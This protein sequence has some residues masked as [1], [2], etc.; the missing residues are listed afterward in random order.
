MCVERG[1]KPALPRTGKEHAVA[2]TD[3]DQIREWWTT[4]PRWNIGIACTA[5]RL[6]VIDIDGP[7][8]VEWI[9]DHHLP[10]PDTWTATTSEGRYHY[11]YRWPEGTRIKTRRIA[12]E[13]EIRAAGAYLVAP[14]SIHPDGGIY[15]WADSTRCDWGDLPEVPAAHLDNVV[16]FERGN[17]VALKR[18]AGLADHLATKTPKGERH[19]ALYT[20]SRTLGGSSPRVTSPPHRSRRS[21]SRPPNKMAFS[22]RMAH[23]T[24][25]RPLATASQKVSPMAPILT[26]ASGPSAIP[27][28]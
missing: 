28:H 19:N 15:R 6:A 11:Y 3:A 18:L 17:A 13:L 14:P 16:H 24:S 7:A 22:P 23:R 26:T 2:T 27:T 25:N 8:G 21:Y 1:K 5:N 12:P 4:N 20:T 10:M 9:K